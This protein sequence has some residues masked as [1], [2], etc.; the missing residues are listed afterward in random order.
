MTHY[1]TST[2]SNVGNIYKCE[3]NDIMAEEGFSTRG[4]A[5]FTNGR[6]T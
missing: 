2:F 5:N 4:T 3:A 6:E 1:L